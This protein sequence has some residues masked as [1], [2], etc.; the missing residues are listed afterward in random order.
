M[1]ADAQYAQAPVD[2]ESDSGSFWRAIRTRTRP[3]LG[4]IADDSQIS[5]GLFA[6]VVSKCDP[7]TA[8]LGEGFFDD[9]YK[10]QLDERM[11]ELLRDARVT[12]M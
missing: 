3:I 10:A 11:V 9:E 6:E 1:D 5:S 4:R 7:S 2:A 12:W 8:R